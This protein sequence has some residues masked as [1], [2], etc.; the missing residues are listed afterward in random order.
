MTFRAISESQ[1]GPKWAALFAE[2]RDAYLR[3]WAREGLAG[4]PTYLE[5]RKALQTHMPELMPIYDKLCELAGGG[6]MEARFL[7]VYCPPRYLTGCSQAIWSGD[8]PLL[9]RNYDYDQRAVDAILLKTAWQGRRVIGTSDGLFGLVDGMNDAGLVASLTFGGR[10]AAGEGFGVP[11]ILRYILQ[12]CTTTA[13]AREILERVPC[14]MSYNVT[15]LDAQRDFVT[16]YLAPDRPPL[17]THAAVATNHQERVEWRS[18]ARVTATVERE[19]YLLQRLSLHP[20]TQEKFVG[21]FLKP[22]LYSLAF[23]RGFGTLYTAAYRPLQRQVDL[24]WPD[25]AWRKSFDDFA[26]DSVTITYPT[27]SAAAR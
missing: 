16:A 5:C 8:A 18:H 14:H 13:E 22:P 26:E 2:Y 7:S 9:V 25:V 17:L 12:T 4:R 6:D 3:W 20:E 27:Q 21:A 11:L 19:R 23:D 15:V 10:L 1:P 24:V